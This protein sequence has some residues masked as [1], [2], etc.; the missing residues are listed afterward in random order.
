M[1]RQPK[2]ERFA[3]IL[4]LVNTGIVRTGEIAERVG[5]SWKQTNRLLESMVSE[6][7]LQKPVRGVYY[8]SQANVVSIQDFTSIHDSKTVFDE[9]SKNIKQE[10]KHDIAKGVLLAW[11]ESNSNTYAH[12][13]E[14]TGA[15]ETF[16]S[17]QTVVHRILE[18]CHIERYTLEDERYCVHVL[19][20]VWREFTAENIESIAA[21]AMLRFAA[22][23]RE[24]SRNGMAYLCGIARRI[25]LASRD[26]VLR[27]YRQFLRDYPMLAVAGMEEAAV[28]ME[29]GAGEEVGPYKAEVATR[30]ESNV[31]DV[32]TDDE[33]RDE[34]TPEW[35]A[36]A[37]KILEMATKLSAFT[38]TT[39]SI[40]HVV[41]GLQERGG[42]AGPVL[43]A[44]EYM[45]C[46]NPKGKVYFV[47][48]L[49]NSSLVDKAIRTNYQWYMT[50][51]IEG[52]DGGEKSP[53]SSNKDERYSAFYEL[54]PDS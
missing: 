45:D 28:G 42:Q 19:G 38:T 23:N 15:Q 27:N 46:N 49:S 29:T 1:K 32:E 14:E 4:S 36:V 43:A 5:L 54:F 10:T 41:R 37:D 24:P 35:V 39:Q 16:D 13:T 2:S 17:P 11:R 31:D 47:N 18:V 34:P 44:L 12:E 8:S 6:G 22:S 20:D 3:S 52:P 9:M 30:V 53:S 48:H 7:L 50:Y 33:L 25:V 51:G 26:R 21:Q 40:R